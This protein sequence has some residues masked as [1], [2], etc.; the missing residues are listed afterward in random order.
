MTYVAP[1]YRCFSAEQHD[2]LIGLFKVT[3][4]ATHVLLLE[5]LQN[6]SSLHPRWRDMPPAV[7]EPIESHRQRLAGISKSAS[8]LARELERETLVYTLLLEDLCKRGRAGFYTALHEADTWEEDL[9]RV[10][11]LIARGAD[12][13]AKDP[14]ALR[15]AR[16]EPDA[17]NVPRKE[18]WEPVLALLRKLE[19]PIGF[20]KKG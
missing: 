15:R 7:D 12:R 10:L 4:G 9:T 14:G 6:V 2:Q 18:V 13:L 5:L 3:D 1:P 16:F 19:R 11:D 20:S 17:R 8:H